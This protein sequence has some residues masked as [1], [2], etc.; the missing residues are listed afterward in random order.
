MPPHLPYPMMQL[1]SYCIPMTQPKSLIYLSQ[2]FYSVYNIERTFHSL[3]Y[4]YYIGSSLDSKEGHVN[5]R[6]SSQ[7]FWCRP[8]VLMSKICFCIHWKTW[9][10]STELGLWERWDDVEKV[11]RC[12]S[13]RLTRDRRPTR[14]L[15]DAN[16]VCYN[17]SDKFSKKTRTQGRCRPDLEHDF[18]QEEEQDQKLV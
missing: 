9:E 7:W 1:K 16:P 6:I 5:W 4:D 8:A 12:H 18:L 13:A 3:K 2:A 15:H 10:Q 11:C 17:L 14:G